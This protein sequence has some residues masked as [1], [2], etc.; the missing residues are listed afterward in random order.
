M[1]LKELDKIDE[2]REIA[3][4]VRDNVLFLGDCKTAQVPAG[5][6]KVLVVA[7][8]KVVFLLADVSKCMED[9]GHEE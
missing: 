3:D 2:A 6:C 7:L 4:G 8:D 9:G 5:I 1:G